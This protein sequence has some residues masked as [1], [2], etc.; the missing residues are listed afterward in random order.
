MRLLA[1]I[2]IRGQIETLTGLHIGSDKN[3]LDIGG[4][5]NAVIKDSQ[6]RPY[7]PGSSLKGKMRCLL[8]REAGIEK[9]EDSNGIHKMGDIAKIFGIGAND[10]NDF[11]PTRFYARDAYLSKESAKMM[12]DK[13]YKFRELEFDYTESKMENV[14]DRFTSR[15]VHPRT[16]ERVPAGAKFDFE[17]VYNVFDDENTSTYFNKVKL[18]M[19]LLQD[20]YIGGSGSRGYGQIKFIV[21]DV[22][23][24]SL[25]NYFDK[26]SQDEGNPKEEGTGENQDNGLSGLRKL[27]KDLKTEFKGE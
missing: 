22:E 3:T 8:E 21:K 5:A 19:A 2:I 7:I 10:N 27:A 20:D 24:K 1:K 26:K 9:G 14:I 13:S 12:E 11:G 16:M 18:G 23:V 25:A 17:F 4:M 15:A 6:G